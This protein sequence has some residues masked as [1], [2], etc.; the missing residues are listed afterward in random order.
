MRAH[1]ARTLGITAAVSVAGTALIT[2]ALVRQFA[3]HQA[4][5]QLGRQ[6]SAAASDT[7]TLELA[8]QAPE[9]ALTTALR[10]LLTGS[11]D[12]VVYIGPQGQILGT[13]ATAIAVAKAADLAPVLTGS[14]VQG[15]VHAAGGDYV[16][17][18]EPVPGRRARS[19]VAGLVL[20]RPVGLAAS[21][22]RPVIGRVLL[23]GGLA[24][25]VAVA[26]SVGI[27][28]RLSGPLRRVAQATSRVAAG[29]L[30]Q[31]VP[32]EGDE[33]VADVARQFNG[34]AEALSEARRREHEFLANVSHELRTPLTA[35][36]GYAEALADG[37]AATVASHAEAVKVIG[38]EAARL[39]LLIRDVMDLAR[40]G[41]RE[42]S[43]DLRPTTLAT[44]LQEA[45][46][47]HA[48]EAA[49]AGVTLTGASNGALADL[50]V[51]TDAGRVRQIVSNLVVNALRV[52]PPGGSVRVAG[53]PE[54]PGAPRSVVIEVADT[55]P[56]IAPADLP[57]V[58]ERSYLW[59]RSQNV[60][61]VG[62]G[63]GLAIVRE[64]AM[65]LGGRIDVV[66]ELGAGTTFSL[67]LPLAPPR[68]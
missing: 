44:T 27:A 24:V 47:A 33:E 50:M 52:T 31:R 37:T 57:H 38:D 67:H 4:L 60:R 59:A 14:R 20:A 29:D 12:R 55:G 36:R 3:E 32:V 26:A 40:L 21:I 66:S 8:G 13:D 1:L 63:L 51:V 22:W 35:I 49:Q 62:T 64:L 45:V 30:A 42:L 54:P 16:Y 9:P 19:V 41:A 5:D 23:A 18:A 56:G 65:A 61:P 46:A 48:A 6:A 25:A 53:R 17:V 58:F 28:R 43:L 34:M 15:Q 11:G 10:Q 39:E 7:V 2:F 68:P